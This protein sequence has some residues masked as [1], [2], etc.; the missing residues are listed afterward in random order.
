M[1]FESSHWPDKACNASAA[2]IEHI[3]LAYQACSFK[4]FA[5]EEEFVRVQI[6]TIKSEGPKSSVTSI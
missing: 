2:N 5:Q 3:R 4:L 1:V 6:V